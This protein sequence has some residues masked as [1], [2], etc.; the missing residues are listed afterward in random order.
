MIGFLVNL[1]LVCAAFLVICWVYRDKDD[2]YG[3]RCRVCGYL[4]EGPLHD[5]GQCQSRMD[6]AQKSTD[7]LRSER[8]KSM[9]EDKLGF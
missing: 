8:I 4:K 5:D 2:D 3:E 9:N 7:A 1:G 6:V